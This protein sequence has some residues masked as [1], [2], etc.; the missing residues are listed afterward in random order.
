M[1]PNAAGQRRAR[2]FLAGMVDDSL[3]FTREGFLVERLAT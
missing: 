1:T 2:R 3:E